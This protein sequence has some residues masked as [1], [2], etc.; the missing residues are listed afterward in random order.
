MTTIQEVKTALENATPCQLVVGASA[1]ILTLLVSYIKIKDTLETRR[2]RIQNREL[3][4]ILK[5][6]LEEAPFLKYS[7]TKLAKLIRENK[8]NP[9]DLVI[10]SIKQVK[11]VNPFTNALC[12][13]NFN[14][15]RLKALEVQNLIKQTYEKLPE[16]Q[17]KAQIASWEINEPLLGVPFISKETSEKPGFRYTAGLVKHKDQ[18]GEKMNPNLHRLI[19]A[20]GILLC[21]GNIPEGCMWIDSDNNIYGKTKNIYD[22]NRAVGGSSGGNA[23]LVSCCCAPFALSSDIGG[24]IRIPA[25]FTGVFGHKATGGTTTNIRSMPGCPRG[26]EGGLNERYCQLGPN[27]RSAE[28][29]QLIMNIISGE[30]TSEEKNE[31]DLDEIELGYRKFGVD[32][33]ISPLPVEKFSKD[34]KVYVL[35]EELRPKSALLLTHKALPGLV[36]AQKEVVELLKKNGNEV[37]WLS[38]EKYPALRLLNKAFELWSAKLA[39]SAKKSFGITILELDE[40]KAMKD[41]SIVFRK[42]FWETLKFIVTFG[43]V[44]GISKHTLP[45]LSLALFQEL[46]YKFNSGKQKEKILSEFDELNKCFCEILESKEKSIIIAPAFPNFAPLHRSFM[47]LLHSGDSAAT[48]NFNTLEFPASMVPMGL[49]KEKGYDR[50]M[51][52]GVQIVAG[53][54]RDELCFSAA[55]FLEDE[56]VVRI[57]LPFEYS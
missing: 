53:K 38:V 17:R 29:M 56:K 27:C 46:D 10:A 55:K 34:V 54:K 39:E 40:E 15:A 41:R 18:K 6:N 23:S 45:A 1:S 31:L 57:E 7:A 20:G 44:S 26:V 51:P 3:D 33:K 14:A 13:D 30:F 2:N 12:E 25:F 5:K 36:N 16:K 37:E 22:L 19:K 28:D 52:L 9:Y 35:G 11:D 47:Q 4:Q 43:G 48:S 42:A 32:N 50:P 21:T 24:S 8:L 49:S